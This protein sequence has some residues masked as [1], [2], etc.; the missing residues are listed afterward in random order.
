[1]FAAGQPAAGSVT[2]SA[3]DRKD[4]AEGRLL[5]RFYLQNGRGSAADVPVEFG[6]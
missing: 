2:L 5:V 6:K 3:A 4:A 1:L